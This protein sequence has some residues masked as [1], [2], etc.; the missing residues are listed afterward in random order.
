MSKIIKY[1]KYRC[2][3]GSCDAEDTVKLFP[4]EATP[5]IL[6]CWKCHAGMSY[7]TNELNEQ[8]FARAGMTPVETDSP[9]GGRRA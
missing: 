6:N 1:V 8:I 7:K 5:P 2:M 4:G 9:Q 3:N